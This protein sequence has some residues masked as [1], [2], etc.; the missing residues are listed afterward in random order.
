MTAIELGDE[1]TDF[2]RLLSSLLSHCLF[3]LIAN[4]LSRR[5]VDLICTLKIQLA[6]Q[7]CRVGRPK[8]V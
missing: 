4:C 5:A 1:A 3:A 8:H 7:T 2:I 6:P